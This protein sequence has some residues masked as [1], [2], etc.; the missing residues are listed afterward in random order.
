MERRPFDTTPCD[1]ESAGIHVANISYRGHL[2]T[3]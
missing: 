3:Q 1:G 2:D